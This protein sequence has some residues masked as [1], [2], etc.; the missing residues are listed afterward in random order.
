MTAAEKTTAITLGLI[1][2]GLLSLLGMNL[3]LAAILGFWFACAAAGT[4]RRQNRQNPPQNIP[5]S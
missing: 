2:A 4:L 3:T 1:I 5:P